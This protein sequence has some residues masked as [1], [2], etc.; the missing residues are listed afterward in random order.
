[1]SFLRCLD[2]QGIYGYG[3]TTPTKRVGD[4]TQVW[5][6]R[7]DLSAISHIYAPLYTSRCYSTTS[8]IY[9]T[10]VS[11]G[12]KWSSE[13]H[14]GSTVASGFPFLPALANTYPGQVRP[15]TSSLGPSWKRT[16]E[17]VRL[18]QAGEASAVP[19]DPSQ[20]ASHRSV[21]VSRRLKIVT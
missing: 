14:F 12:G 9:Q 3:T 5:R 21:E 8:H 18:N 10:S 1:M 20:T 17:D 16:G 4:T 11:L 2:I 15:D 7:P 13:V 6:H 19:G